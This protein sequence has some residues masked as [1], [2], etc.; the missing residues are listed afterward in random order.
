M[1][2]GMT[3][4]ALVDCM[5]PTALNVSTTLGGGTSKAQGVF[6]EMFLTAQ[7]VFTV[8]MLAAEKHRATFLAP[9]G[10]GLV[11]FVIELVGGCSCAA[12]GAGGAD[13][14][15]RVLHGRVRE[16][17]AQLRAVRGDA[18]LS[19]RALD[20]LG[21]AGAGRAARRGVLQ[22][23]QDA[24]VRERGRAPVAAGGRR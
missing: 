18:E 5:F 14:R 2:G 13:G 6:I 21:R 20:L 16:P 8:F 7:L 1:L 9:I 15:R 24:R 3:A 12:R 10:I 17:R 4:A 23:H 19:G 22:V 11:F